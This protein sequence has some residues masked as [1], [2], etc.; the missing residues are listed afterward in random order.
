MKVLFL[1]FNIASMQAIT[2]EALNKME[3]VEAKCINTQQ[4]KYN[5]DNESVVFI[6]KDVFKRSSPVTSMIRHFKYRGEIRKW[7]EWADVLHYVWGPALENGWD[8][9]L[10][11][12]L[13]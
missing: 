11:K 5:S 13:K 1:P 8:L 12:K 2:A 6:K 7:I 4:N 3:G 9:K 10:A